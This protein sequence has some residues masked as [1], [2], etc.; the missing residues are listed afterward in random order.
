MR[1]YAFERATAS[2]YVQSLAQVQGWPWF[3]GGGGAGR[4]GARI[5]L[6][7]RN[8]PI[9]MR[10]PRL[11][12]CAHI[13]THTHAKYVHIIDLS[14]HWHRGEVEPLEQERKH[15]IVAPLHPG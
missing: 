10:C 6:Q 12:K 7:I 9:S 15:L 2:V 11:P 8:F 14:L 13:H 4:R 5:A 3:R 1:T